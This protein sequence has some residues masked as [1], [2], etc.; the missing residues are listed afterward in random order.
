[1][2]NIAKYLVLSLLG[3][4]SFYSN[5][6]YLTDSFQKEVSKFDTTIYLKEFSVSSVRAQENTPISRTELSREQILQNYQ[7]Q[8]I[9]FVLQYTPSVLTYSD[10]GNFNGYMYYRIRG[11]DQTRI[12]AT[13]DGVPL[14][15]PEDQG[16]YF[17]NY[18]DFTANVNS[19]QIQRGVGTSSNGTASYAGSI[20]FEGPAIFS[21]PKNTQL[22]GG[23]GS[24]NS[25]RFSV[26]H[27]SGKLDNGLG[28]YARYSSVSSDGYRD[29]SGTN[30]QTFFVSTGKMG[31][32]Y[33]LKFTSFFGE[34]DNE[35]AYLASSID[36]IEQNRRHNPLNKNEV[37]RFRQNLNILQYTKYAGRTTAQITAYYNR[38][39]GNY[40]I[41]VGDMLNF[42]LNSHFY[43]AIATIN[44]KL[45]DADITIGVHVNS[46]ER[47]HEMGIEPLNLEH[48]YSN[49]G[50]K[51]EVSAF[52][53]SEI[54]IGK[55][56]PYLDVQA[57]AVAFDYVQNG[58]AT[59][60]DPSGEN[61]LFF[62]PK[63]GLNFEAGETINI[64]GFVGVSSREPTRNDM[65]GGF[66][67]VDSTN[68]DFIGNITDVKPE[69]VYDYEIGVTHKCEKLT[70]NIN[71]Y[72]M[73]FENEITPIGRLSYI[74]LPLRK[75]VDR[76]YRQGVEVSGAYM[77]G[78]QTL[79]SMNASYMRAKI[80]EY[81][82][83][84]TSETFSDV[85]P[86]LT[87]NWITNASIRQEL[88]HGVDATLRWRYV[89]DAFLDNEENFSLVLPSYNVFDLLFDVQ[90]GKNADLSINVNNIF[91]VEYYNSGYGLG[92]N[93]PA[94]FVAPERNV[95]AN[96]IVRL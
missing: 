11:L 63:A 68:M 85:E 18:P 65:L 39:V 25:R 93:T 22:E 90:L 86:L 19:I 53:K 12:N 82:N 44:E 58:S 34:S 37:D 89:S 20:S 77:I 45:K 23:F 95:Y 52:M 56:T 33:S 7:G 36:D 79:L 55:F 8:D 31:K 69:T 57:R 92:P 60:L 40:D 61:W 21:S 73:Q 3:L 4:V 13:L 26:M 49:T 15:E 47:T 78:H 64:Y 94:Y 75:N 87:P 43:G 96:L 62:N 10:G 51:K 72:H 76:S 14:N 2:K 88:F 27:N 48:L 84:E 24:F 17:S 32:D 41:F 59:L 67:D 81:T 29:N 54:Y 5:A 30:G 74:G 16:A 9:P 80:E 50:F 42:Q 66:D 6:Q 91:D 83:D 38:L 1:M 71:A 46:Y 70:A 35:M 28:F